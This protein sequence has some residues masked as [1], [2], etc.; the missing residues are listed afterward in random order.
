LLLTASADADLRLWNARTGRLVRVLRGHSATVNDA[1]FSPDGRWIASAGPITVGLWETRTGR[2][3]D[4]GGPLLFIRG[5][6]RRRIRSVAFG[7]GGRIASVDD[8]G[9]LRTYACE[10]C[11][12]L[13]SLVR[14]AE[15]RLKSLGRSMSPDERRRYLGE[16]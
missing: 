1:V 6:P 9:S 2:R 15:R 5:N 8:D 3:L 14:L 10:I 12:R 16:R 7:A 13:P 11:G 4:P